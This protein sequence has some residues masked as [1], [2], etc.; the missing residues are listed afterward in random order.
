MAD[1]TLKARVKQSL[2]CFGL[3]ESEAEKQLDAH[4]ENAKYLKKTKEIV[5]YIL[6]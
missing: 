3:S 6:A 5:R 1:S 4:F 2:I